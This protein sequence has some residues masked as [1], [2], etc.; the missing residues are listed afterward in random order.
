MQRIR[1]RRRRSR[2]PL[3][4]SRAVLLLTAALLVAVSSY[5]MGYRLTWKDAKEPDLASQAQQIISSVKPVLPGAPAA[6]QEADWRRMVGRISKLARRYPGHVAVELEDLSRGERWTYHPDELFP[7]AS[8]IKVPIMACVFAKIHEG[9]MSLDD[10]EV[11]GRKDRRSGSGSL[12]WRPAGTHI[13]VRELLRHMITE[14]DNTAAAVFIRLLG[15]DYLREHFAQL[16][17]VKTSISRQGMSL[18]SGRVAN[19]N[20]TTAREMSSLLERI[21]RGQLIDPASSQTMLDILR[22]KKA[23]A[24]RLAKGLPAGWEIAH[25]T[26]LLRRACHDSAIIFTPRGP[27]LMTVLTGRNPNYRVAKSFITRLGHAT[28][29]F[30]GANPVRIVHHRRRGGHRRSLALRD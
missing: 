22:E 5:T 19:E 17:L 12:K 6:Q 18:R 27:Y 1:L 8:L 25:K 13:T 11:I 29:P 24:T 20:Y 3:T 21:Y 15:Y 7:S 4:L 26:G 14:S 10:I 30:W 2:F 9:G 23:V 28:F 16:G